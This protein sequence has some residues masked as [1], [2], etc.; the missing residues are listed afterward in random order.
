MIPL[1]DS[2]PSGTVPVV[3]IILIILNTIIWLYEVALGEQVSRFV[4]ENGLIPLRFMM[5]YKLEGGLLANAD[6]PLFSSMFMHGGWLHV[7]GNMWFLWIFGDNVEDRLGHIKYLAFYLLCGIGASLAHVM[8]NTTSQIPTVGASGA[9]SG[10]LGAYL[11]CYPHARVHTLIIIFYFIR[12]LEVP[13]FVFLIIWFIFQL[14]SGTAQLGAAGD[15]A[16]VAYWSH[17]GGFVIGIALIWIFGKRYQFR[18]RS[19]HH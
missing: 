12:F 3:T 2:N 17:M 18:D 13:A 9:I 19:E 7:V 15:T 1:R 6:F 10:V 11:I 16:G 8:F 5:S 4:M 14:I